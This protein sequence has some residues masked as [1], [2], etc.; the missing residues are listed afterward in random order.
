[1]NR[2][3]GRSP[4]RDIDRCYENQLVCILINLGTDIRAALRVQIVK[5]ITKPRGFND[6]TDLGSLPFPSLY[7]MVCNDN[8]RANHLRGKIQKHR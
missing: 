4:D 8:S 5:K 2:Y 3:V 1:M 7:F 6:S